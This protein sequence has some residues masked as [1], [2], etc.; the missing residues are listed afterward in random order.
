MAKRYNKEFKLHVV[1]QAIEE[2]KT[3]AQVSR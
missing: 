2:G 1:K 3:A